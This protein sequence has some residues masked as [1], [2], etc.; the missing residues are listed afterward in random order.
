[1]HNPGEGLTTSRDWDAYYCNRGPRQP[2]PEH[3]L[4]LLD[5]N[6]LCRV[7]GRIFEIGCGFSP[8]LIECAQH[9]W[10]V[11][12]IDFHSEII[13]R[14]A[15]FLMTNG[16][17]IGCFIADDALSFD[18]GP[19]EGYFDLLVSFG[20]LE[21]FLHP[22]GII[23]RWS[24]ILNHG[25]IVIS[26]VPNLG[27]FNAMLLRKLDRTL[28][29][30]H[31]PITPSDLDQMHIDAGLSVVKPASY[32]ARYEITMLIPWDRLREWCT[33]PFFYKLARYVGSFLIEPVA[34]LA[35]DWNRRAT[36]PIIYGLYK[37]N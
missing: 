33:R 34:R 18:V 26:A 28:W 8:V 7:P 27:S 10:E 4:P 19:L 22:Q 30:K 14:L 17:K 3:L 32:A 35:L 13:E 21:H 6:I 9:G 36:C 25:G 31:I 11:S 2:I 5:K 23:E 12:G 24:R 29:E 1:M 15:T 37:K 16:G 20:F